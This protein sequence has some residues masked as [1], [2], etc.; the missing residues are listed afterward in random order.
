MRNDHA[1]AHVFGVEVAGEADSPRG[2]LVAELVMQASSV[3][4][5]A[6]WVAAVREVADRDREGQYWDTSS[7][8]WS[9]SDDDESYA[10][11]QRAPTARRMTVL[12]G[13]GGVYCPLRSS[14]HVRG[15]LT[16][17]PPGCVLEHFHHH[18]PR[19]PGLGVCVISLC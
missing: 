14:V 5:R 4:D 3:E 9:E 15:R 8:E 6:E 18:H 13:P 17:A 19:N 11:E 10:Y 7:D 16:R 12:A 2:N 1:K